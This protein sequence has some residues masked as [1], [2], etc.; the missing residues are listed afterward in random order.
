[1]QATIPCRYWKLRSVSP[2]LKAAI[3]HRSAPTM[4]E[5]TIPHTPTMSAAGRRVYVGNL[6]WPTGH[7]NLRDTFST[8]G[9]IIEAYVVVDH[10]TDYSQGFGFVRFAMAKALENTGV[11]SVFSTPPYNT[12][13]I[14][15]SFRRR[16]NACLSV[17]A[18]I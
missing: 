8:C 14:P 16:V 1:M 4:T 17:S 11:K 6:A 2:S 10:F 12:E 5:L 7:Q 9:H 15:S 18:L 13:K 3:R